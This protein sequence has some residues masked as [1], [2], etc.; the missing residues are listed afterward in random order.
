MLLAFTKEIVAKFPA[1][2]TGQAGSSAAVPCWNGSAG[3]WPRTTR[4]GKRAPKADPMALREAYGC[5]C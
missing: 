3:G 2:R 1:G 5:L 4:T